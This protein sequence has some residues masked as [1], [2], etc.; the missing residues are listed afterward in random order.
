MR[1]FQN[2]V[3]WNTK[4]LLSKNFWKQKILGIPFR[5]SKRAL[6]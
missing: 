5:D 2:Y 1:Q 3:S 4:G 6:T